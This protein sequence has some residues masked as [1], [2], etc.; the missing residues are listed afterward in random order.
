M[1]AHV[2]QSVRLLTML[3]F[4]TYPHFLFAAPLTISQE[5]NRLHIHVGEQ[6]I[7]TYVWQDEHLPRPYFENFATVDGVAVTRT[8]PTDP[9]IDADNEDHPDFHPGT[10]LAFGDISGTDFW[11]NKARVRHLRFGKEPKTVGTTASFTVV[12]AYEALGDSARLLAEETC[13][14]TLEI[15]STGYLLRTDSTFHPQVDDFAFGDQEEMGFGVRMAT[16]LTV[17]HGGAMIRNS[18]GGKQEA[19]T[20]GKTAQWCAGYGSI[21]HQWVGV[22]VMASP[23]NF[24]PAWF[25]SRDYGLLVANP[26]GKKAMTGPR[27]D[28]IAPDRTPVAMDKTLRLQFGIYVFSVPENNAPPLDAFYATYVGEKK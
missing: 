20:W 23:D 26:F 27:D 11:R 9:K 21:D 28:T 10:W 8:H 17:R 24:R 3:V 14:Y 6:Q 5:D 7:T 12:N 4:A 13:T 25:H 2:S 18:E 22:S 15:T 16:P 19:G 1:T